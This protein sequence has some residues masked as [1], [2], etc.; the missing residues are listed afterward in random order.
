MTL[1]GKDHRDSMLIARVDHFLISHA[2][3]WLDDRSDTSLGGKLDRIRKRKNA[4][5]ES[6]E[7][8]ARSPA[9]LIEISTES[10]RLIWPA[11]TPTNAKSFDKQIALDLI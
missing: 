9:F 4:S 1:T 10:T 11:P 6:T 8:L 7:P 2:T 5:D 3:T